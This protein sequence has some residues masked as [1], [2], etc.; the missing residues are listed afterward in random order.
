ML[1]PVKNRQGIALLI[2]LVIITVLIS[3]ILA[4]N[5]KARSAI[6]T[7]TA[8]RDRFTLSHMASSAVHTAMVMLV[9]DKNDSEIDSVQED[10][11]N[12]ETIKQVL[13]VMEFDEGEVSVAI[14]DELGRIQVNALVGFPEGRDF[15]EPQRLLWNR[16]L[17]LFF[18]LDPL[19]SEESDPTTIIS[20]IKDW[21]DSGDDDAI[22]GLSGAESDYYQ[23]LDP[24]YPCRN[25]P[26]VHL[27][28]LLLVKGISGNLFY[29]NDVLPGLS[30]YLT[31]NGVSEAE[32]NSFTYD[33]KININT[34]E[35]A[36]IAALLPSESAELAEAVYDYRLEASDAT[37][38]HDLSGS[39]WYKNVPGCSDIEID[40]DL[41]TT[42]TDLFRIESTAALHDVKISV[43]AIVKRE[44]SSKTGK[45]MCNILKWRYE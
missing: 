24:P 41:I 39:T 45:W 21:L 36:V 38:I 26:Y 5:T 28:E 8:I 3:G 6:T 43:T 44:K 16:F 18:A 14:N 27:N 42:S 22:T 31:V 7:T 10:W 1:K 17:E 9:K 13:S 29:G 32:N 25:G 37:Y 30:N 19:F 4:L 12:P 2:T 33:G 20:S 40:A 35:L 11:A 15:V 23:D 34:A